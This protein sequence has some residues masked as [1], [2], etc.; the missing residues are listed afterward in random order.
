M[1]KR[2]RSITVIGVIFI[3]F[4]GI[5]LLSSLLDAASTQNLAEFKAKDPSEYAPVF[6]LRVLALLCGVF[7]LYG[8]N[9]ARWLL[10]A[11]VGYH[12]IIGFLHSPW[13]G[14]VHFLLF[15]AILYFL[16]RPR[17][18]AYFRGLRAEPSRIHKADDR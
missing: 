2:P 16:F 9:W 14:F 7:I 8:F 12:I 6:V 4:G 11:W 10:G 15:S 5:A 18:S 13:S 3:A 17:A 1:N